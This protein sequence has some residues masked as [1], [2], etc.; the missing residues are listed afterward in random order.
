MSPAPLSLR[1][2][3][4]PRKADALSRRKVRAPP[5]GGAQAEPPAGKE[6]VPPGSAPAA[7]RPALPG[8][9]GGSL[10][11]PPGCWG[12]YGDLRQW[13]QSRAAGLGPS[14]G[15]GGGFSRRLP[16][17]CPAWSRPASQPARG[18]ELSSG[19]A[20]LLLVP[21]RL[22]VPGKPQE[23]RLAGAGHG[24]Q[25]RAVKPLGPLVRAEGWAPL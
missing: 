9:V 24:K 5:G 12:A 3:P 15:R 8:S 6:C 23:G 10:S 17:Q 1:E 2:R 21:A 11:G 7:A 25:R 19:A 4:G 14:A 18:A 13:S 22:G 16:P 20:L